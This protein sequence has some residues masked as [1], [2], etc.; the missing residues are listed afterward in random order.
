MLEIDQRCTQ[1]AAFALALAAWKRGRYRQL[2]QLHVAC[3]GMR[4]G[5]TKEEWLALARG[6]GQRRL[7]WSLR[8][9]YDV[10]QQAPELGS[11]IDPYRAVEDGWETTTFTEIQPLLEE[12][13][14][15]E[16]VQA[17]P[18]RAAIGVVA[19]GLA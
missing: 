14:Q 10:F 8:Q 13:L 5:A 7:R 12:A 2:P 16:D 11:L 17:D 18:D 3:S 6:E 19:Q 1:I 4:I 9:L 15:Q